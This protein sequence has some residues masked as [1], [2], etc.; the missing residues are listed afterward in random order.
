MGT[1]KKPDLTDPKLLEKLAQG[2]G[3]NYYGEPAWPNDLL[4]MF[5]VVILGTGA[6]IVALSVLDPVMSGEPANPFA[7]PLEI[8][9]E[10]Y[11]YPVFQILRSVP[12]KLLGVLAMASVP[13]GLIAVPF[14]ENVNKFQNPF[15]RP[16]ATTV[17]MIGTIIT[18][19]LGIGATYPI[20]KSFTLGL[21]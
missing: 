17:F 7:T 2:M 5:P 18:L 16:V 20:D 19:W 9:P 10:W 1:L 12:S 6:C 4:Y 21:F 11:L 3:H 15:R 14:I 8:L 13:I